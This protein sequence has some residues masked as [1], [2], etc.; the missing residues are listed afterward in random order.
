MN[1]EAK[2]LNDIMDASVEMQEML[3]KTLEDAANHLR[4]VLFNPDGGY[5]PVK[6]GQELKAI[7]EIVREQSRLQVVMVDS[8]MD[9]LRKGVDAQKALFEQAKKGMAEAEGEEK[10]S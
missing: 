6:K 1:D 5:K 9:G 10:N 4:D 7:L 2:A 3:L 8:M